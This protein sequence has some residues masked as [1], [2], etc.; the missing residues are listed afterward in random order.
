MWPVKIKRNGCSERSPS[1]PK[2]Q[3]HQEGPDVHVTD[4]A[5]DTE[6]SAPAMAKNVNIENCLHILSWNPAQSKGFKSLKYYW[7]CQWTSPFGLVPNIF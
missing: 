1:S 7:D 4:F 5:F 2:R 6:E 3:W